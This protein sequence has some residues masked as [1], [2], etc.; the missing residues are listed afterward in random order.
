MSAIGV[1]R[2]CFA[3][4]GGITVL[5]EEYAAAPLH[6]RSVIS[7]CR[8]TARVLLLTTGGGLLADEQ[9]QIDVRL[10]PQ[11]HATIGAVGAL[12][13]L[14]AG[15]A[16]RQT[17]SACLER[18]SRLVLLPEPL[19]PCAGAAYE[20]TTRVELHEDATFVGGEIVTP[21]RLASGERFA[22]RRLDLRTDIT[23]QGRPALRERLILEPAAGHVQSALGSWTHLGTLVVVGPA[24]TDAC[25]ARVRAH[26]ATAQVYGGASLPATGVIMARLLSHSAHRTQALLE[27]LA[28]AAIAHE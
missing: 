16:C 27:R 21:G 13:L 11:S 26:L 19:I 25:L 24:A 17:L 8:A 23:R 7:P 9:L 2:L 14:P 10:G 20:Q 15:G 3:Q 12:R 18:R 5:Q 4:R 28:A 6:V 1:A 22:Y